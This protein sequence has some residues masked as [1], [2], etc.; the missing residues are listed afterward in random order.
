MEFAEDS[1]GLNMK[2]EEHGRFTRIVLG[3]FMVSPS[4]I[5]MKTGT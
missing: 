4:R 5:V 3:G 2:I 1:R